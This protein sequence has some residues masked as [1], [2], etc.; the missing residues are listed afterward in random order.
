MEYDTRLVDL[1]ELLAHV[2]DVELPDLPGE[3][4]SAHPLDPG[5]LLHAATRTIGATLG[6]GVIVTRR[7]VGWTLLGE[8][9]GGCGA[10]SPA[11]R[12]PF[13]LAHPFY[14]QRREIGRNHDGD[15]LI[16]VGRRRVTSSSCTMVL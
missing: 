15:R 5:P 3:D 6:L 12:D 4:R 11:K 13:R 16:S 2:A 9:A 1:H 8:C 7:L 10:G 14:R